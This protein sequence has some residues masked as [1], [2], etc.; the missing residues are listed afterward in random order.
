MTCKGKE[1]FAVYALAERVAK[2]SNNRHSGYKL[3]A[4]RCQDCGNYHVGSQVGRVLDK[5][6]GRQFYLDE[7]PA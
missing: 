7:E 3:Q 1:S 4:Y 6:R 2:L 5:R